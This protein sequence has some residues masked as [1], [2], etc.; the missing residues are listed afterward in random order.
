MAQMESS[1]VAALLDLA[2]RSGILKLESAL[3]GRV[4]EECLALYNVDGSMRKTAI[5]S[6]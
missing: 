2:Q 3:E 6:C 5:A 1:G 4:T